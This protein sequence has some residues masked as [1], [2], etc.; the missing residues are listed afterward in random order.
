MITDEDLEVA[1]EL[2]PE[3]SCWR[4]GP[5]HL[6]FQ[7]G[8][9]QA[10]LEEAAGMFGFLVVVDVVS[11]ARTSPALGITARTVGYFGRFEEAVKKA[12]EAVLAHEAA[13]K[14]NPDGYRRA[15]E[16]E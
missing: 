9:T 4:M 3:V 14:L 12:A 7:L 6:G 13:R 1:K 5:K 8:P 10:R 16:D 11:S 15:L 2:A